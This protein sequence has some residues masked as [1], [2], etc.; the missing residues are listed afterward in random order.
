MILLIQQ[1]EVNESDRFY[2]KNL[3][4]RTTFDEDQKKF[5]CIKINHCETMEE[6]EEIEK[7]IWMNFIYD[8]DRIAM[9]FT[10]D[11][12]D[13]KKTLKQLK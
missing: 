3:L 12:G 11:Q 4:D 7:S 6:C 9:G 2:L 5:I 1:D 10:Y 8:K 13:I